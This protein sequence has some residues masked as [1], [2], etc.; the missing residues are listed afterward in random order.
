ML[1]Y[2]F[3]LHCTLSFNALIWFI[4]NLLFILIT[5]FPFCFVYLF[6]VC[7]F[8][9]ILLSVKEKA[10]I[11]TWSFFFL[12]DTLLSLVELSLENPVWRYSRAGFRWWIFT[13][14]PREEND[15]FCSSVSIKL[16]K[17]SQLKVRLEFISFLTKNLNSENQTRLKEK[18]LDWWPFSYLNREDVTLTIKQNRLLR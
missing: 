6:S 18:W 12:S 8:F 7:I 1:I 2:L 5:I 17:W 13:V 11:F 16:V 14:L 15:R 10:K 3:F 4:F 9:I